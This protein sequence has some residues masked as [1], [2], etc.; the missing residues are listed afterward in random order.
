DF[1]FEVGRSPD[2]ELYLDA[3]A[4]E[5]AEREAELRDAKLRTLYLG[6]GTPS[7]LGI[8]GLTRLIDLL[9]ARIDLSHIE[10]ATVELNPEHA[11]DELV[12]A[13]PDL[14]LDRVSLGVQSFDALALSQL[15]RVHDPAQAEAAARR[16]IAANLRTSIDL[17]VGWPGQRDASLHD[18]LARTIAIAPEH[19]S[20]YALTIEAGTPWPKLV[21]RGLRQLPDDDRQADAIAFAETTLS[22]AGYRHYEVAS[23]AK[24]DAIAQHNTMYWR[25]RSYVGLGPSAASARYEGSGAVVRRTNARGLAA[26]RARTPPEIERLDP[27]AAAREG[28]WL[29]L[30]RLD[31]FEVDAYLARFAAIDRAWLHARIAPAL[32]RGDLEQGDDGR[33]RIAP[34]RWL[35][36][37]AIAARLLA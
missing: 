21:R 37:D 2:V 13:L 31:G 30:R 19:V 27:E 34:G 6:G 25:W 24:H 11:S 8:A 18:D 22:A 16:C 10:E 7:L 3:L 14:G 15:G 4:T 12:A 23:Y 35:H 5:L 9:R 28:L 17:I 32:A 26:W 20:V 36:A 33:L 29:G 1:D